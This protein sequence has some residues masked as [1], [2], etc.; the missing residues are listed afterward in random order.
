MEIIPNGDR[1]HHWKAVAGHRSPLV[2]RHH[3]WGCSRIPE[4]DF[5]CSFGASFLGYNAAVARGADASPCRGRM[6]RA[7]GPCRICHSGRYN[8]VYGSPRDRDHGMNRGTGHDDH[9]H[10]HDRQLG[11]GPCIRQ[12]LV[13][14][15]VQ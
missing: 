1:G 4:E 15:G 9:G 3:G 2:R 6:G 12:V 13:H 5:C 14:E 8:P 11:D 10:D 7:R